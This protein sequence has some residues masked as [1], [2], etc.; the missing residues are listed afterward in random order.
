MLTDRIVK[1]LAAL[2]TPQSVAEIARALTVKA[3]EIERACYALREQRQ[4][5][6]NGADTPA[7]P[8]R[9]YLKRT[10]N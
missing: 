3:S 8:F 9:F 7:S 5:G 4:L 10:S 1:H 2:G 6:R